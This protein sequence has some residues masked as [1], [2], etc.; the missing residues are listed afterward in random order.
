MKNFIPVLLLLPFSIFAQE[1]FTVSGAING[2]PDGSS[3]SI[4]DV[5]NPTDTLARST[6]KAGVFELNG[7]V[8]EPN[9]LQLNF[10]GVKKK[11]V[12]FI[13]NESVQLKGNADSVQN[14]SVSGS[15][16]HTDFETFKNTFNPMFEKLAMMGKDLNGQASDSGMQSYKTHLEK[17]KSEVESFVKN[18]RSSPVA[19]FLLVVTSELEQDP[20]ALERRYESLDESVKNGFYGSIVKDQIA[21]GKVGRV[22]SQASE[23]TQADTEGRQVSLSSFR[24][25]YVLIDFWASWCRPCRMENPNVVKAFNKYKAKNFTVLGISLDRERNSWLKAI[26]DDKLGW[27]QLSDLKFWNNEVAAKYNIQSIPQNFLID[28]SGKIIGKNLRGA[29]LDNTLAKVLASVN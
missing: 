27:T 10:D 25:K 4:S 19:P 2:L 7:S 23:F 24:G 18:K 6:V 29:E 17:I 21:N 13:G 16:S 22:G 8:K 26:K 14:I 12:I 15:R 1:K 11:S 28:P 5:N 9:L 20:V 3:V